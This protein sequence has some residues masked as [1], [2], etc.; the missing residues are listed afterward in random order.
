MLPGLESVSE[1]EIYLD[2]RRVE[3]AGA[4]SVID[5]GLDHATTAHHEEREGRNEVMITESGY[6]NLRANDTVRVKLDLREA[7]LFAPDSGRRLPDGRAR[8]GR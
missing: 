1:G 3:H 4:E 8:P 5:V 6:S 2:Q 7:V